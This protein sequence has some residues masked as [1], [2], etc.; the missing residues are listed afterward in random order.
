MKQFSLQG[1]KATGKKNFQNQTKLELLEHKK[2]SA[3]WGQ[4]VEIQSNIP[5]SNIFLFTAVVI[6]Q[7]SS[8][9]IV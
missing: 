4:N 1:K 9:G 5:K 8:T 7:I 3:R 2:I 6:A